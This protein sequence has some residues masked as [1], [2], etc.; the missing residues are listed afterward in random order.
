MRAV[1]TGIE[2]FDAA[3]AE[4]APTLPDYKLFAATTNRAT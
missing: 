1:S 4:L 2:R 3:I